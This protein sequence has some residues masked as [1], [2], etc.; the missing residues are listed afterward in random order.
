[1]ISDKTVK[2]RNE[3]QKLSLPLP[4]AIVGMGI[5]GQ[6]IL[7]LLLC[8][9]ISQDQILTFD[10][11]S[12]GDFQD[13]ALLMSKN[14]KTLCVS[15][16]IP[17]KSPWIQSALKN[18]VRLTSELEIAFSFLTTE[19]VVAVTGSV[20][21]S[22]VTALLGEA[23]LAQDEHAFVGGNLGVPLASYSKRILSSVSK[24]AEF[25]VLELS[26]Y[27]LENFKNLKAQIGV[28]TYLSPNHLERYFSLEEYY[29]T[30]L[31]LFSCVSSVGIVNTRGGD[32]AARVPILREKF[33]SLRWV[34]ADQNDLS[35]AVQS[36]LVGSHNRDNLSLAFAAA[37]ELGV[38]A[39]SFERMLQ[40][41]GLPHRMESCGRHNE[42]AFINDSKATSIDSVLQA[43]YS[44]GHSLAKTSSGRI[45]LLLGGRDKNLPWEKLQDLTKESRLVCHF[46]GEFG[47][48]I[49]AKTLLPGD[50]SASLRTCLQNLKNHLHLADIVLLSPGGTSLDEFKNFEERGNFFKSWIS[51][52][53]QN[54]KP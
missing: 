25:V 8:A 41:K 46:F 32:A 27:Q 45:H 52:E 11:K 42:I 24:K 16:G 44:L 15:P 29:E 34:L 21:K 22:T 48:Q 2:M 38:P 43:Y 1:M 30:K 37:K 51:S 4:I 19:R 23:V 26:S 18:G 40:F 3:L 33:S 12:G 35:P 14:P 9:G 31:K 10:Q 54:H 17:L 28:L 6:A 47:P 49:K 20:G 39:A 13:P 5:T 7:E 36:Q 50:I 53:F